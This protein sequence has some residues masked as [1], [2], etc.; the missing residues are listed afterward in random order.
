MYTTA[1]R[2][3]ASQMSGSFI[4]HRGDKSIPHLPLSV[5]VFVTVSLSGTHLLSATHNAHTA[6]TVASGRDLFVPPMH[7]SVFTQR[8]VGLWT[9]RGCRAE[10]WGLSFK[11]RLTNGPKDTTVCTKW[12][13]LL[14]FY[15]SSQHENVY[16]VSA[17]Q[18]V[19]ITT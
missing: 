5:S 3:N 4:S 6:G 11:C 1:Q 14:L 9:A 8:H 12:L 16:S 7:V 13:R 10:V 17:L 19:E 2:R 15:V 18:C